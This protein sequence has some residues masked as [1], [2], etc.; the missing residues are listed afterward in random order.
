MRLFLFLILVLSGLYVMPQNF[1][2]GIKG[3]FVMSQVDGDNFGG[4]KKIAPFGGAYV[5]NTFNDKWGGMLGINYKHKG[6]KEVRRRDGIVYFKHEIRLDYIEVPVMATYRF[7]RFAIPSLFDVEFPNDFFIEFGIS[8]A[9]LLKS[10]EIEGG[11]SVTD[12]RK[13]HNNY[14][15]QTHQGIIYRLSDNF[16]INFRYSWTFF[17]F[18]F[19]IR[20][21]PGGQVFWIDRGEYNRN[22]SLSLMWEF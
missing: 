2:G 4:F 11:G 1:Y 17:F 5:R 22:V 21:H 18:P 9:Y 16:L 20:E 15:F 12:G 6:S 10:A 13:P 19:P 14:D 7:E 8:Y 3:G